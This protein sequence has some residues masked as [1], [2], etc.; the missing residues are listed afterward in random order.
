[1]PLIARRTFGFGDTRGLFQALFAASKRNLQ[2]DAAGMDCPVILRERDAI[3]CRKLHPVPDLGVDAGF[4]KQPARF[5]GIRVDGDALGGVVDQ[6][7][8][9]TKSL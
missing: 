5:D 8:A 7:R 9:N 3:V 6:L 2:R 4:E 1:M